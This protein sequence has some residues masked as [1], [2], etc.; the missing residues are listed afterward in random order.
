MQIFL[1][2]VLILVAYLIGSAPQVAAIA[3]M[4]RVEL[5]GDY[6]MSL[7]CKAGKVIGIAGVLLEFV[8]GAVPVL[9]GKALGF[10]LTIVS[11]AGIVVVCGQMWP[12]FHRFDGEKGN[13]VLVG[14]APALAYQPM[15]AAVIPIAI[16]AFVRT[17]SRLLQRSAGKKQTP[18]IGGSYSRSL[19]LGMLA[20]FLTLPIASYFMHQPPVITGAFAVLFVLIALRRLTA[21]LSVDL[22]ASRDFKRIILG[23]LFLDRGITAYRTEK[24]AL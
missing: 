12:V 6:H 14:M 15:M 22:K 8:R 19:P 3:R 4:R 9:A 11:V 16:G 20:G 18:V 5:S 23:R 13:T 24:T 10:D 1:D 7:W 17:G 21:G 2:I